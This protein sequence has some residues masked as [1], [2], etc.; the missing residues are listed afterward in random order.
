MKYDTQKIIGGEISTRRVPLAVGNYFPGMPLTYKT[1]AYQYK[2]AADPLGGFY[3]D[4]PK[5]LSTIERGQII[6]GGEI[7]SVGIVDASGDKLAVTDDFK[8]SSTD[9]GFY[10]K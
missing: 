1:G 5:E 10:I 9:H 4:D 2:E 7:N 8:A 6:D 3:F